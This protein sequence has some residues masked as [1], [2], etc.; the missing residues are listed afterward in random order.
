MMI[1]RINAFVS[2]WLMVDSWMIKQDHLRHFMVWTDQQLWM[3][4]FF[5]DFYIADSQQL[6]WFDLSWDAKCVYLDGNNTYVL[7][8]CSRQKISVV[9]NSWDCHPKIMMTCCIT[10]GW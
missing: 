8:S 9:S 4:H 2:G 6:L 1:E 7:K 5:L 3:V 10:N